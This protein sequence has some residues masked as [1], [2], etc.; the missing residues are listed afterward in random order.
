[1]RSM[2]QLRR[3]LHEH[4]DV[5]AV[6]VGLAY[7]A[8][9]GWAMT[10]LSYDVWGA[11]VIAPIIAIVTVP[12]VRHA[13][14][15]DL[16]PLVGV[17]IAGLVAKLVGTLARYWVAFDAYGGA[18]DAGRYHE[19][20]RVLA[21]QARSSGGSFFDLIPVQQGTQ[22]IE[23][24]TA[25][26]YSL[27]GSSK[28]AGFLWFGL[29]GYWGVV[30]CVKAACLA[31]PGLAQRRYAVLCFLA[32]SLMFWPSSIGKEA[33]LTLC[34]GALSY[35]A[36][37]LL[38]GGW[39]LG[40]VMPTA[41][42]AAGAAMVRPHFAAIWLGAL[43]V[44]M[45]AG[46]VTGRSTRAGSSRLVQI[47]LALVAVVGLVL[48]ARVTLQFLSPTSDDE[49]ASVSNS[50]DIIGK[51]TSRRSTVGGSSF[52][53]FVVAG[54]A[55]YPMTIVR[56]LTRPLLPEATGLSTLIPAL[57]TTA[58][59]V[60]AAVGWRRLSSLPRML[61]TTP[62]VVFS[63]LIAIMGGLAFSRFGNLAILVRQRSLILP[64]L[65]VL[66]C[67][68]PWRARP[69]ARDGGSVAIRPERAIAGS[70]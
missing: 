25:L 50:L 15:G 49:P 47:G 59:L 20:G 33:W 14:R 58:L 36:A 45:V 9:T 4:L 7:V 66:V 29:M 48:V 54:P 42:G 24:V 68:P 53:P 18:A 31:V 38:T 16:Q 40:S 13:F 60:L 30:F 12:M 41:S 64:A 56:T 26:L 22:F 62:Y 21:S 2:H 43:V 37:K 65:L 32:P 10:Y 63:A 46:V 23:Q 61:L 39:G 28:L 11:L 51:E 35:G 57:E 17:A 6:V 27:V 3:A 44:A 69:R 19:A 1:M 70:R 52:E 55:D 67:L 5:V 8:F 34:L